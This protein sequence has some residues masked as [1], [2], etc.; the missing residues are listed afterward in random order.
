MGVPK[1]EHPLIYIRMRARLSVLRP[2]VPTA[3]IALGMSIAHDATG[4]I[5]QVFVLVSPWHI[6]RCAA[7][8]RKPEQLAEAHVPAVCRSGIIRFPHFGHTFL[9]SFV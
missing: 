8:A 6:V 2:L 9:R 4:I 1:R 5:L 3:R 7:T